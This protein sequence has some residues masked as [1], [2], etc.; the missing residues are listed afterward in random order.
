MIPPPSS[1]SSKHS[2][3]QSLASSSVTASTL[4]ISHI[5]QRQSNHYQSPQTRTVPQ[6][7]SH[8]VDVGDDEIDQLRSKSTVHPSS[9]NLGALLNAGNDEFGALLS[10]RSVSSKRKRLHLYGSPRSELLFSP[11][12]HRPVAIPNRGDHRNND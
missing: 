6:F 10:P 7:H 3:V 11:S 8:S 2:R 5:A 1:S 9:K 4:K 12:N